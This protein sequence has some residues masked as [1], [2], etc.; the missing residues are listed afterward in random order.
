MD[1]SSEK[2]CECCGGKYNEMVEMG[3]CENCS[4]CNLCDGCRYCGSCNCYN[5]CFGEYNGMCLRSGETTVFD[6][7]MKNGDVSTIM[8][9]LQLEC[10]PDRVG[11]DAKDLFRLLKSL[12][13]IPENLGTA[14]AKR[15]RK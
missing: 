13:V 6:Q 7:L 15:N 2:V 12:N 10:C 9:A 5:S 4:S 1:S 11:L 14:G 8:E 3:S